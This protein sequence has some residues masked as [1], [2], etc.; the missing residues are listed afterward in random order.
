LFYIAGVVHSS[1]LGIP[2]LPISANSTCSDYPIHNPNRFIYGKEDIVSMVYDLDADPRGCDRARYKKT[3]HAAAVAAAA[4]AATTPTLPKSKNTL[5]KTKPTKTPPSS[6]HNNEQKLLQQEKSTVPLRYARTIHPPHSYKFHYASYNETNIWPGWDTQHQMPNAYAAPIVLLL[7]FQK[8]IRQLFLQTFHINRNTNGHDDD[9]NHNDNDI[10][11]DTERNNH[12]QSLSLELSFIFHQIASL[13]I[14]AQTLSISAFNPSTFLHTFASLP[15]ASKLALLDGKASALDLPSRMEALYRFLVHHL[16]LEISCGDNA[17]ATMMFDLLQ[18]MDFSSI[19]MFSSLKQ[20]CNSSMQNVTY[21]RVLTTKL[22]Y[23]FTICNGNTET[24]STT[25]TSFGEI[26]YHSFH[27]QWPMRAWCSQ[28]RSYENGIQN[29]VLQSL[30]SPLLCICCEYFGKMNQ[31]LDKVKR[32][33]SCA[34]DFLPEFIEIELLH[35]GGVVVREKRG[36]N[37]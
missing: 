1:T 6:H 13:S 31:N 33:W 17:T 26:L 20:S 2:P 11:T 22:W 9:N 23:D 10:T 36:E 18:G 5:T 37:G 12:H 8:E 3:D 29:K 30:P 16:D 7:Y 25:T 15:K 21:T 4:A 35:G 28:T 24:T 14:H 32:I 27:K 34:N 19:H